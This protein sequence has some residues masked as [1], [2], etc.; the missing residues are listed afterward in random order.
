MRLS[1]SHLRCGEKTQFFTHQPAIYCTY[2]SAAI[3]KMIGCFFTNSILGISIANTACSGKY[4]WRD[5][6]Y[7]SVCVRVLFLSAYNR[8]TRS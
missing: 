2:F 5:C 7:D 3:L 4:V 6:V 8:Q 1:Q